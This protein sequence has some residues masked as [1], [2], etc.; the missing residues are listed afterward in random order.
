[1]RRKDRALPKQEAVHLLMNGEYGVLSTVSKDAQPYGVPLNYVYVDGH[2][3]FHCALIGHKLEN[4]AINDKVSFCIVG[5]T[6]VQPAEFSTGFESVIVFGRAGL[7]H[8]EEKHQALL[9]LLKK[10]CSDFEE[11]GRAYID[12]LN[13]Q[14]NV[15]RV[16]IDKITGK[17]KI[18]RNM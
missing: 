3:Y 18:T 6:E 14:T 1:M 17:A 9:G 5:R 7:V 4:I 15:V 10:Y 12:K 13:E 8:E 2:I 11:R 16:K